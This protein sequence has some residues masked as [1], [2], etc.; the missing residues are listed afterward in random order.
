MRGQG[1]DPVLLKM[2]FFPGVGRPLLPETK[3]AGIPNAIMVQPAARERYPL[4]L[5]ATQ[6]RPDALW[7]PTTAPPGRCKAELQGRKSANTSRETT[8][9]TEAWA[10]ALRIRPVIGAVSGRGRVNSRSGIDEPTRRRR[11]PP[12]PRPRAS[13]LVA[14]RGN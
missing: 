4:Q 1:L 2:N 5:R 10:P 12:L 8:V 9:R 14:R 7:R 6:K 13:I 11:K 3:K